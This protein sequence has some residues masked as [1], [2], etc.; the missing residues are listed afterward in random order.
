MRTSTRR[1][2]PSSARDSV[3]WERSADGALG[4]DPRWRA[5]GI[6]RGGP[7]EDLEGG[8]RDQV[9]HV[10]VVGEQIAPPERE[11]RAAHEAAHRCTELHHERN[12]HGG[13]P[14]CHAGHHLTEPIPIDRI[15]HHCLHCS[16]GRTPSPAMV[17]MMKRRC[18][19][20]GRPVKTPRHAR[21][22]PM[23][24]PVRVV[25]AEFAADLARI[26]LVAILALV[27]VLGL[28]LLDRQDHD[29]D[30]HE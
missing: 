12:E 3:S 4:P 17:P 11:D 14:C 21:S 1:A 13:V 27:A 22:V 29:R 10:G 7:V 24:V 5:V 19:N 25:L 9:G 28:K 15:H 18:D 8:R 23:G 20:F 30:L 26:A 2:S 16:F 6:P